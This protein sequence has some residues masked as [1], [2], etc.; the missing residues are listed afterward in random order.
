MQGSRKAKFDDTYNASVTVS[1]KA[2]EEAEQ[3]KKAILSTAP[4]VEY[5]LFNPDVT[6]EPPKFSG[7][8]TGVD[9]LDEEMLG[10]REKEMILLG[11]L[12]NVGK[13][14]ISLYMALNFI[15]QGKKVVY[16]AVEDSKEDL[17]ERLSKIAIA[18]NLVEEAKQ[19]GFL[20][21]EESMKLVEDNKNFLPIINTLADSGVADIFFLDMLNNIS[22][23]LEDKDFSS[24][25]N[26]MR[27]NINLFGYSIIMTCRFRQP[28][29]ASAV[30]QNRERLNPTLSSYFGRLSYTYSAT[31]CIA[32]APYEDDIEHVALIV[33]K[34]KVQNRSVVQQRHLVKIDNKLNISQPARPTIDLYTG[35]D[36][37][38]SNAFTFD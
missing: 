29:G 36:N 17:S 18:N 8:H 1:K 23:P 9:S 38:R 2:R 11:A 15:K 25:W 19:L 37:G 32:I 30:Q 24:L 4:E 7:L 5:N 22:D 28:Q 34:T 12:P 35:E 3:K 6:P 26:S 13:T 27:K 16:I 21:E 31:K 10:I 14:T 33:N 20:C